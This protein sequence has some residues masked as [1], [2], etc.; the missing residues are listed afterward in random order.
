MTVFNNGV[1]EV[2]SKVEFKEGVLLFEVFDNLSWGLPSEHI[3]VLQEEF[4]SCLSFI[5]DG[6]AKKLFP[7]CTRF[8]IVINF[9]YQIPESFDFIVCNAVSQLQDN[10]FEVMVLEPA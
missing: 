5:H 1:N 8:Q 3:K 10:D 7:K 6:P 2:C 9:S 4:N